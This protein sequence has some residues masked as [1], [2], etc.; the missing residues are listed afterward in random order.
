MQVVIG[1][2]SW[3]T[4]WRYSGAYVGK[5]LRTRQYVRPRSTAMRPHVRTPSR[6]TWHTWCGLGTHMHAT[7][8]T[9]LRNRLNVQAAGSTYVHAGAHLNLHDKHADVLFFSGRPW[10]DRTYTHADA[11]L[12]DSLWARKS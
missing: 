7:D 8:S 11:H 3:L 6:G 5:H 4:A 10:F 2:L 1:A 12:A 9:C